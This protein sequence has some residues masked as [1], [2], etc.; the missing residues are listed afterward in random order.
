MVLKNRKVRQVCYKEIVVLKSSNCVSPANSFFY[1]TFLVQEFF[2]APK[3]FAPVDSCPFASRSP[4]SRY[5]TEV[6]LDTHHIEYT[7]SKVRLALCN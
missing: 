1:A 7:F 6:M 2:G 5:A 4:S 3:N